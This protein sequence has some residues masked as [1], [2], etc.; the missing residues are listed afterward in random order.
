MNQIVDPLGVF[1]R[2]IG[3]SGKLV[4]ELIEDIDD[5]LGDFEDFQLSTRII[6]CIAIGSM[7]KFHSDHE[8]V[9]ADLKNLKHLPLLRHFVL[10]SE[11]VLDCSDAVPIPVD[12]PVEQVSFYLRTILND[13]GI[14]ILRHFETIVPVLTVL[15]YVSIYISV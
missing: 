15:N 5:G 3:S 14:T 12:Q 8:R 4:L 13:F 7:S 11:P 10:T 1:S 2:Q 6:G 9:K